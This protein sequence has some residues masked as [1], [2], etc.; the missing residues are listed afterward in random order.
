LE[1][2]QRLA[3]LDQGL[4]DRNEVRGFL[5]MFITGWVDEAAK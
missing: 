1:H 3:E 2:F 5:K 4:I